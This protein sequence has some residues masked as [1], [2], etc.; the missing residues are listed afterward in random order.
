MRNVTVGLRQF[1]D[2]E[3]DPSVPIRWVS[4]STERRRSSP[5]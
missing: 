2:R 5:S 4:V 1:V 3:R